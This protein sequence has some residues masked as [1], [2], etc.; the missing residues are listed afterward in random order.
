MHVF[1]FNS[2]DDFFDSFKVGYIIEIDMPAEEEVNEID[3]NEHKSAYVESVA[4]QDFVCS[5]VYQRYVLKIEKVDEY[6]GRESGRHFYA[7][8][9]MFDNEKWMEFICHDESFELLRYDDDSDS[10]TLIPHFKVQKI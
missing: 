4:D 2:R 6:A 8:Q 5:Y 1:Q 7:I 9:V 3:S 10:Y